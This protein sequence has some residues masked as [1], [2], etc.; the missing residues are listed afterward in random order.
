MR[1]LATIL[2]LALTTLISV[3]APAAQPIRITRITRSA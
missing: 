2:I 1:L 3:G